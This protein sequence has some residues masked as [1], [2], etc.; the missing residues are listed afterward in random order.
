[1][2]F[3]DVLENRHSARDF[4]D[5][6]LTRDTV[7]RII[8]AAGMAPSAMN[9]QPWRFHVAAGGARQ[10]VGAVM[11]QATA[12]LEEYMSLIGPDHYEMAVKWYSELGG[13]P[14]V[15]GVSM[16]PA[17]DDFEYTNTLLSIGAAV[18][19][20]LLAA[21]AEGLAACNVTFLKWLGAGLEEVFGIHEGRHI[22]AVIALGHPGETP[23]P[24]P[25]K[26]PDI[27]DWLD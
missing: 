6:P 13:A 8:H 22:V 2:E 1:M 23:P 20:L 4:S 7:E 16:A 12:H 10:R 14:V 27:S 21:T 17:Q 15:I 26:N 24:A 11:A 3:W 5:Q 18:E 25:P 19:N 9:S